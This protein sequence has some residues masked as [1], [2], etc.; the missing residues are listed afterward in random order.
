[1]FHVLQVTITKG[2]QKMVF[3]CIGYEEIFIR[4]ARV[5]PITTSNT[6]ETPYG[7]P[8]F[9]TLDESLSMSFSD[10]L[11]ERKIDNDLAYFVFSFSNQ[12]E[13]KQYVH[14]LKCVHD[15]VVAK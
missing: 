5:L 10:Y 1:V 15:Y 8:E 14:W 11:A 4:N 12:Q 6:D 3:E 13:Q 2:E 9:N 7:G